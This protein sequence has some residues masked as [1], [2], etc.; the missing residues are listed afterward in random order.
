MLGIDQHQA[1]GNAAL[2]DA[3]LHIRG[4]VDEGPTG[5]HVEPEFFAVAFHWEF[6]MFAGG[7]VEN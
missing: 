3:F 5:G 7:K 1:L 2:I 4:D 6:H